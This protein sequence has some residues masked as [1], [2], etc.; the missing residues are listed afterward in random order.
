MYRYHRIRIEQTGVQRRRSTLGGKPQQSD[1]SNNTRVG[2]GRPRPK[3][4]R[5]EWRQ[6]CPLSLYMRPPKHFLRARARLT[7]VAAQ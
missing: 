6:F 3:K 7:G 2:G 4:G 1:K 5:K